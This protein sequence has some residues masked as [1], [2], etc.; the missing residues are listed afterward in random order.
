MTLMV[1]VP[2]GMFRQA[3]FSDTS[4]LFFLAVQYQRRWSYTLSLGLLTVLVPAM[5]G[6]LE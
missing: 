1:H 4:A 5:F 6:A 2:L 3:M